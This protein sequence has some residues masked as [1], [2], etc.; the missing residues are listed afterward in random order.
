GVVA[1]ALGG[2]LVTLA[3]AALDNRAGTLRKEPPHARLAVL[4]PAHNEADLIG[5]CVSSL[6]RQTYPRELYRV[7]VVADNCSDDTA[8]I[9]ASLG[10]EVLIRTDPQAAGKGRALRWAMDAILASD[11]PIDAFVVVDADSVV[12]AALLDG[13]A[14]RFAGGADAVQGEYLALAEDATPRAQ[15]RSAAFLL[16]HRVRFSGRARLR[17]PCNLVGNGM[18]FSA[19]LMKAHPW[20]AFSGAEDLEFTVELRLHGVRPVFAGDARVWAPIASRGRAA[21]TQRLRWEGGGLHVRRSRLPAVLNEIVLHRRRRLTDLAVDLATPP[22][23]VL[24]TLAVTGTAL[25]AA[26]WALDLIGWW[27]VTP[28]VLTLAAVPAH[29]LIGL[30]AARAPASTYRALLHAPALVASEVATRLRLLAGTHAD[31][32][33]RTP[34]PSDVRAVN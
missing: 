22:L 7:V 21:H 25:G 34:R 2:Y 11:A 10:A 16:F 28:W 19:Q 8:Q 24:A 32:W 1:A 9:A 6:D 18:L 5:R 3:V 27:A 4:V 23:G 17:L 14:A 12:D 15:L 13:L 30:V 31:R 20:N 26:L 33:E 29:V